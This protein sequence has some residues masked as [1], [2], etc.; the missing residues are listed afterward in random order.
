MQSVSENYATQLSLNNT[1][2]NLEGKISVTSTNILNEVSANYATQT[3][4]NDVNKTLTASLELKVDTKK[5]ISEINASADVISLKAGRL[6][7][8]SG[9]FKL[10]GNGNI[11]VVN[12]NFSGEITS[13]SGKIGGWTINSEGLSNGTVFIK[14]DGAS[15]IYTVADLII[16]RGYMM[17]YQGFEFS[18]SMIKHYDI[19]GD[20]S[21]TA[22]DY[23]KLETLIG[24][25]MS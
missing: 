10:D 4:L 23:A 16:M 8:T 7:I 19:D 25:S 1:I 14:N 11:T 2:T 13:N 21:V 9:N 6:V 22:K 18:S 15:T 5:L 17:K 12:G 3:S 20:G 24:I